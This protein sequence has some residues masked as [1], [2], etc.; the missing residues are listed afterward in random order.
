MNHSVVDG[1]V[2]RGAIG[3]KHQN[4]VRSGSDGMSP[5]DIEG[6][7]DIPCTAD[8]LGIVAQAWSFGDGQVYGRQTVELRKHLRILGDGR[9]AERIRDYDGLTGSVQ[10]GSIERLEIV[11]L[12]QV[13]GLVAAR[14]QMAQAGVADVRSIAVSGVSRQIRGAGESVGLH[15]AEALTLK[16]KP[17]RADRQGSECWR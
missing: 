11:G 4:D 5:F 16:E 9:G 2:Q 6:G 12:L 14:C 3:G 7:F 15:R 8:T 10:T 1:F 13:R 17:V